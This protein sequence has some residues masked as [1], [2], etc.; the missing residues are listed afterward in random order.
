MVDEGG[1][2]EESRQG[3]GDK[4]EGNS[5]GVK[6]QVPQRCIS[7]AQSRIKAPLQ[8]NL[9]YMMYVH[10]SCNSQFAISD[11]CSYFL[12]ILASV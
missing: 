12:R 4:T 6:R 8:V 3:K 2:E 5:F 7:F 11:Q 9:L 10:P 1:G